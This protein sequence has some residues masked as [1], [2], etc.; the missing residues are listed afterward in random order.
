MPEK[1]EKWP[2]FKD[3]NINSNAKQIQRWN[4][5]YWT[6]VHFRNPL[7]LKRKN[8]FIVLFCD[9]EMFLNEI[10]QKYNII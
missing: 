3:L 7:H 9:L 4:F 1:M 6:G 8:V 5:I 10:S 2:N